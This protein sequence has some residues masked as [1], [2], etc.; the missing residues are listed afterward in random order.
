MAQY[1]KEQ[2]TDSFVLLDKKGQEHI[3]DELTTFVFV[4]VLSGEP[5]RST[6]SKRYELQANG[7][8]LNKDPDGSFLDP[9]TGETFTRK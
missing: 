8:H 2:K 6:G 1:T 4:T 3:A 7:H 5:S 9:L